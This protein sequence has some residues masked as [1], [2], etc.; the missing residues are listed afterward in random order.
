MVGA[1]DLGWSLVK[2]DWPAKITGLDY[3]NM[4]GSD[5]WRCAPYSDVPEEAELTLIPNLS[6]ELL[7]HDSGVPDVDPELVSG[8]AEGMA[9]G[10]APPILIWDDEIMDGGM[11]LVGAR[12]AGMTT[13]PAYVGRSRYDVVKAPV[14]YDEAFKIFDA[15]RKR[16]PWNWEGEDIDELKRVMPGLIMSQV[17]EPSNLAPIIP[18]TGQTLY[19]AGDP[20][21]RFFSPQLLTAQQYAGWRKGRFGG[22]TRDVHSFTLPEVD[23]DRVYVPPLHTEPD[24]GKSIYPTEEDDILGQRARSLYYGLIDQDKEARFFQDQGK[25]WVV[26][27]EY[28]SQ[29]SYPPSAAMMMQRTILRDPEL[30]RRVLSD[31]GSTNISGRTGPPQQWGL[32]YTGGEEG[33]PI[34]TGQQHNI[35][36]ETWDLMFGRGTF[37]R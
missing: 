7:A 17:N 3:E 22:N 13:I 20:S 10:Q 11:R 34:P 4:V 6:M 1:F 8:Y 30:R 15:H 21:G 31:L 24:G 16:E 28:A 23:P 33:R 9:T 29:Y 36:P 2:N 27:P 14:S 18:T 37:K 5:C 12:H 19:R 26:I 35:D 32:F 25:D